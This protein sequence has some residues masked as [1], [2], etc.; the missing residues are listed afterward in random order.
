MAR[1][2]GLWHSSA[3]A[4]VVGS[5]A[6]L[7]IVMVSGGGVPF[8]YA[9]VQGPILGDSGLLN[10]PAAVYV[11]PP[12]G[13]VI[14]QGSLPPIGWSAASFNSTT[15]VLTVLNWSLF[16]NRSVLVA[17]P[18]ESVSCPPNDLESENG[19]STNVGWTIGPGAPAGIGQ[20]VTVP[21][22]ITGLGVPSAVIDGS[23]PPSP[24]GNFTWYIHGS[25]VYSRGSPSLTG[26]GVDVSANATEL[27]IH[28]E[29]TAAHFG[30]PIVLTN[31]TT[32][33]FPAMI[34]VNSS[35]TYVFPASTD[36]G[37]WDVYAAGD[38]SPYSIGGYLFVETAGP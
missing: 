37:T 11:P 24:L 16:A 6:A 26:A 38:G 28:T 36:Q 31:D 20:R 5:V 30:V 1:T 18:G 8:H 35:T 7:T 12:G 4:I 3:V 2:R 21:T 29:S 9:C 10:S 34:V 32:Q 33:V 17:G 22:T 27:V 25:E 13:Q 14:A 23:Y 19:N 15:A